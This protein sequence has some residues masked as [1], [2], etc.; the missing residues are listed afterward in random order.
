MPASHIFLIL[1]QKRLHIDVDQTM[2]NS[3]NIWNFQ[4]KGLN[5]QR[6]R[7]AVQPLKFWFAEG[8]D[9]N[10][11]GPLTHVVVMQHVTKEKIEVFINALKAEATAVNT[12]GAK[13]PVTFAPFLH[14]R[15][16][17]IVEVF[18]RFSLGLTAK[19]TQ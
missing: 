5:L 3:A 11:G 18:L 1:L 14:P 17:L 13:V 16:L 8:Y 12:V 2:N 6:K 15:H 9:E 10:F 7:D 19:C 4:N